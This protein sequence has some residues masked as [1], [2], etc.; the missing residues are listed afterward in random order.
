MTTLHA[1]EARIRANGDALIAAE[2]TLDLLCNPQFIALW[3]T[4]IHLLKEQRTSLV[5]ALADAEHARDDFCPICGGKGFYDMFNERTTTHST[6]DCSACKGSGRVSPDRAKQLKDA[7]YPF[8]DEPNGTRH[9]GTLQP[10]D[11][12]S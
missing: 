12:Q 4:Y 1:L 3:Q 5:C 8:D 6:E 2:R 7:M 11:G 10:K 9:D